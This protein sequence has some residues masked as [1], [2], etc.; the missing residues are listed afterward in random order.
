MKYKF[1]IKK[2]QYALFE[3]EL[4]DESTLKYVVE[5]IAELSE[6]ELN[7]SESEYHLEAITKDEGKISKIIWKDQN[8]F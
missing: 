4:D 2:V 7:F 1:V 3:D 5:K 8:W 6:E